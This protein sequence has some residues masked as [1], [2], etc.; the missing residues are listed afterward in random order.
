[1]DETQNEVNQEISPQNVQGSIGSK[2]ECLQNS[3][4][5]EKLPTNEKA[6]RD[7]QFCND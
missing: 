6:Q 7:M 5:S 2:T 3:F 1:M 4:R